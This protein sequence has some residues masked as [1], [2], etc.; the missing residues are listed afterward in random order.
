MMMIFTFIF[1]P[2]PLKVIHASFMEIITVSF[3][4]AVTYP[5]MRDERG[6]V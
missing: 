4:L 3:F 2:G 6:S 1:A 5:F